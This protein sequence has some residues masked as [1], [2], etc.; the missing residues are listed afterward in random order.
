MFLSCSVFK[1]LHIVIYYN[2]HLPYRKNYGYVYENTYKI[3]GVFINFKYKIGK[4]PWFLRRNFNLTK[5]VY[6]L[7]YFS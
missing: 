1:Y 3:P 6:T 2:R 7:K 4:V 5:L